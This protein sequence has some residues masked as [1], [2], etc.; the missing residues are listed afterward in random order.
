MRVLQVFILA[1]SLMAS[2]AAL[3][4][5]TST[6]PSPVETVKAITGAGQK[7]ARKKKAAMC[8]ECGKPESECECEHEEN[9][10]ERKDKK[11]TK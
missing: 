6:Q 5:V 3:A 1:S 10:K 7:V 2:F 9:E 8:Q 4:Q 11:K